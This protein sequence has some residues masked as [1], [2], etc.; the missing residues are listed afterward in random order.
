MGDFQ[1]IVVGNKE[2]MQILQTAA[3]DMCPRGKNM[4]QAGVQVVTINELGAPFSED[5]GIVLLQLEELRKREIKCV[6][7]AVGVDLIDLA[8]QRKCN[9]F[10]EWMYRVGN[11]YNFQQVAF[12]PIFGVSTDNPQDLKFIAFSPDEQLA[13]D[14]RHY[15]DDFF[16]LYPLAGYIP[17]SAFSSALDYSGTDRRQT[18][19][20]SV[21]A[22]AYNRLEQHLSRVSAMDRATERSGG[23]SGMR[24]K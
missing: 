16:N 2:L 1:Q 20:T 13:G 8:L 10:A 5:K 24:T 14:V 22:K 11:E 17:A 21:L 9:F 3:T 12:Y 19:A 18:S 23:L 15:T 4:Q 7:F 6:L